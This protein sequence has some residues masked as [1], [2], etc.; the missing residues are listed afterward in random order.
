MF[1]FRL[2]DYA[3][4][5]VVTYVYTTNCPFGHVFATEPDT[6][7]RSIANNDEQHRN[8]ENQWEIHYPLVVFRQLKINKQTN[9]H[10]WVLNINV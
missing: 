10:E 7:D 1:L 9:K 3:H 6:L 4:V 2:I 5:G 8:P